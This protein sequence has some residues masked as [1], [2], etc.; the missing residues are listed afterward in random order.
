MRKLLLIFLLGVCAF[1]AISVF[2][3][4]QEDE[5]PVGMEFIETGKSSRILVPKGVKSKKV[6]SKIVVEGTREYMARR[7]EEIDQRLEKIEQK[8]E[9]L[10]K[11]IL[12]V[13]VLQM[14]EE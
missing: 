6:G 9:E 5:P 10:N 11:K 7:F 3:K 13:F 1:S 4:D 8:Q 12:K 14:K 2:A